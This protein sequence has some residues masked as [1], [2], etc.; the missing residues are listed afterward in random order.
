MVGVS[1]FGLGLAERPTRSVSGRG[2]AH[3]HDC[4]FIMFRVFAVSE[5]N[6]FLVISQ[7]HMF[8]TYE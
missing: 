8:L 1:R 5:F 3:V 2:S 7:T 6:Y 4:V